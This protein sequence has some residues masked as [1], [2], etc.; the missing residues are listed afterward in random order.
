MWE[1]GV[2]LDPETEDTNILVFQ[3][4]ND[5]PGPFADQVRINARR[6]DDILRFTQMFL[7]EPDFFPGFDESVAAFQPIDPHVI[8]LADELFN[9]LQAVLP[10]L[11]EEPTEEWSAWPHMKVELTIDQVDKLRNIDPSAQKSWRNEELPNLGVVV[12]SD[13]RVQ[14]LFGKATFPVNLPLI[15]LLNYWA[16]NNTNISKYWFDGLCN[17]LA[18]AA[19][20]DFPLIHWA[21]LIGPRGAKYIPILTRVSRI[22]SQGKMQFDIYFCNISDLRGISVKSQMI[23]FSNI[24]SINL[25]ETPPDK[26]LLRELIERLSREGKN[27]IPLFDGKSRIKYIIHRSMIDMYLAK[28]AL[29]PTFSENASTITLSKILENQDMKTIF[30]TTYGL[31][32]EDC[33]LSDVKA[34]MDSI[35]DCRDVFVTQNGTKEEPVLGWVTNII[36]GQSK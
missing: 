26:L 36:L 23:P 31:V 12:E 21:H 34:R 8:K 19:L 11:V 33:S 3:C 14:E 15:Q 30:E 25:T 20:G 24:Y 6:R 9:K 13:K 32:S 18:V 5:V 27:R 28:C 7:T 35:P 16:Q 4:G 2:A 1:C 17:Q 10:P 22:P 29:E